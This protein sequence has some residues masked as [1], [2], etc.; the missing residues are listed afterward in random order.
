MIDFLRSTFGGVLGNHGAYFVRP[1][2][3]PDCLR[4][5]AFLHHIGSDPC[6]YAFTWIIALIATCTALA[7]SPLRARRSDAPWLIGVWIVVT[8]ASFVERGNFHFFVAVTPFLVA[9][10]WT[11]SKRARTAAAILT[12][13]V[14]ILAQ[15]FRHVISVTVCRE[16]AA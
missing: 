10:L 8:A 3:L 11:F 4:S 12:A 15:P 9:A 6:I 13:A 7:R 2:E 5:P 16:S 14:I 1:L